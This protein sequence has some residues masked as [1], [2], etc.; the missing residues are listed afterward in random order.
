M[1]SPAGISLVDAG[2]EAKRTIASA[3][4]LSS[5]G[6]LL[7]DAKT[8]TTGVCKL[9]YGLNV[10]TLSYDGAPANVYA[11]YIMATRFSE[12]GSDYRDIRLNFS[13][14]TF[15]QRV[16]RA[17]SLDKTAHPRM[18][19]HPGAFLPNTFGGVARLAASAKVK[20]MVDL[21]G[22][23]VFYDDVLGSGTIIQRRTGT[24]FIGNIVAGAIVE[25]SMVNTSVAATGELNVGM[26][27]GADGK[28]SIVV[29]DG[30]TGSYSTSAFPAT[31]GTI[32][33]YTPSATA[34]VVSYQATFLD[35]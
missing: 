24:F 15:I 21:S 28:P 23:V 22:L 6:T 4:K 13:A 16:Y 3:L 8:L 30:A 31:G 35:I 17:S 12:M 18:S 25:S 34:L 1:T 7:G 32:G 14:S 9:R 2:D 11:P 10:I 27:Y 33:V 5:N 19:S 26:Y 29:A 20:S